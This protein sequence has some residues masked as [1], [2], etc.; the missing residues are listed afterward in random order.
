MTDQ[1]KPPS[2]TAGAPEQGI[3]APECP[4]C[5]GAMRIRTV[6]PLMFARDV[7]NVTYRCESC[8]T[9]ISRAIKRK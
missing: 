1:I 9:E 5:H 7:D 4:N 8:R 6:E 3:R 2:G